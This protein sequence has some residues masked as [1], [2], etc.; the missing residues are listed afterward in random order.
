M[1]A[2]MAVATCPDNNHFA[3]SE[4]FHVDHDDRS[5][6]VELRQPVKTKL[7]AQYR[8]WQDHDQH[9]ARTPLRPTFLNY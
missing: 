3:L 6:L 1:T 5:D 7:E 9:C 2:S 4:C 8:Q